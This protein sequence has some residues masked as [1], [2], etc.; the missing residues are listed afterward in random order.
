MLRTYEK[1][2]PKLRKALIKCGSDDYI[3]TLC[4]VCLNVIAGT[5]PVSDKLKAHLEKYKQP[6]REVAFGKKDLKAKRKTLTQSGGAF[7]PILISSVLSSLIGKLIK[8]K[9]G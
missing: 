1:G 7:L 9:D 6:L 3:K 4:E 5:F 2:S 8:G